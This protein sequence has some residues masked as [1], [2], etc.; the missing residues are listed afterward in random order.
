MI[1]FITPLYRKSNIKRLML[2]L[3]P[4]IKDFTLHLIEGSVVEGSDDLSFLQEDSRV[5]LYKIDTQYTWGHEQR[6]YFIKNIGCADTDWCYFLDDDNM[7]TGDLVKTYYEHGSDD[8]LDIILF[9]QKA[10]VTDNVRLLSDGEESLA[11]GRADIGSFLLRYRVLKKLYISY[12]NQ[13]NGDG[14]MA[15]RLRELVTSTNFKVYPD[16]YVRYN[17]FSNVEIF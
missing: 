3:T 11:C 14:H 16:R 12:E 4:Q 15:E 2:N 10:G 7:V 9:S 6:N 5:K 17:T 1:H 13:R 8:R